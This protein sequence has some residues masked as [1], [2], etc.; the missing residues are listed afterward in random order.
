MQ[1]FWK[2]FTVFS[3][4]VFAAGYVYSF[5]DEVFVFQS[6]V[7]IAFSLSIAAL[8]LLGIF[9]YKKY[10]WVVWALFG[11]IISSIIIWQFANSGN[12]APLISAGIALIFVCIFSFKRY[13]T[14]Y[15]IMIG[16]LL[17][18]LFVMKHFHLSG[19]GPLF[20]ISLGAPA[21]MFLIQT[22]LSF[23]SIKSNLYLSVLG[24]VCS[25]MLADSY[26]GTLFKMQR[27][28]GNG[29]MWNNYT[30]WGLFAALSV[31]LI[32]SVQLKDITKW[33]EAQRKFLIG[34]ILVPWFFI[35]VW[36]C[37]IILFNDAYKDFFKA[38]IKPWNM[39]EYEI[40]EK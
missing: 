10:S 18:A 15:K 16:L 36:S 26:M 40:K 3:F 23:T 25:L 7:G 34:N 14:N 38:K 1:K 30:A 24:A 37:F 5:F 19:A 9:K 8:T 20:V 35:F 13:A 22:V 31:V 4:V 28:P 33:T 39:V 2:Y 32:L 11:I 29:I 6:P 12:V 21:V 17:F 27:W